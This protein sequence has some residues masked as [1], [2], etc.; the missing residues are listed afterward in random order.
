MQEKEGNPDCEHQW[1]YDNAV[2]LTNPPL[3]H[4]ICKLCGRVEHERGRMEENDDFEQIHR[5]FHGGWAN[6]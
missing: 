6:P 4:K 2:I 1:V 5:E 3:Y